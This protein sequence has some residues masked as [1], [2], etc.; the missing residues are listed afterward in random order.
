MPFTAW[1]TIPVFSEGVYALTRDKHVN[2]LIAANRT[3]PRAEARGY[4]NTI[5]TVKGVGR[6]RR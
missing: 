6:Q 2:G 4:K 3:R 5:F 1:S